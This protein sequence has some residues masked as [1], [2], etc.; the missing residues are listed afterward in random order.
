M[1]LKLYN[2]ISFF[3]FQGIKGT[4]GGTVFF[5]LDPKEM[6]ELE[7]TMAD[8]DLSYSNPITI[9]EGNVYPT[10]PNGRDIYGSINQF[11]EEYY[12]PQDRLNPHKIQS[13]LVLAPGGPYDQGR[14]VHYSPDT[15]G[16]DN[17][18]RTLNSQQ[19]FEKFNPESVLNERR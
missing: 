15:R 4:Q 3:F 9:Q 6:E 1:T 2:F 5:G 14:T 17:R 16:Y 19:T 10:Y 13:T 7:R 11:T 8:L 12:S 18:A